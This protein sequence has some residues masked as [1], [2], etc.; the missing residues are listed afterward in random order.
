[1]PKRQEEKHSQNVKQNNKR[2][3]ESWLKNIREMTM[4]LT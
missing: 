3:T 4:Q 2:S 1:M